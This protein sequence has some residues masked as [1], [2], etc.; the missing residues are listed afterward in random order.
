[1]YRIICNSLKNYANDFNHDITD[2]RY[3]PIHFLRLIENTNDYERNKTENTYE[4]TL[5]SHF[6]WTLR[7]CERSEQILH[8]LK[9]LGI[10][11]SPGG[12]ES[13]EETNRIWQLFLK[14]AYWRD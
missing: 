5:L 14:K 4:Y 9:M 2:S 7:N 13:F 10:E 8:E 1:M 3:R 11:G 12:K 6:L